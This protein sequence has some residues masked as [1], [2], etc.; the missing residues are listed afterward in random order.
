MVRALTAGIGEGDQP[1]PWEFVNKR[2]E[3]ESLLH[4]DPPRRARPREVF[5]DEEV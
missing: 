2:G 1:G 5:E 3:I 4:R